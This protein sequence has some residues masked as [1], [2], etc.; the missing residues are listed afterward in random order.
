MPPS[1]HAAPLEEGT[2]AG[3]VMTE[4][5]PDGAVPSAFKETVRSTPHHGGLRTVLLMQKVGDE[6]YFD[7]AGF[8]GRTMGLDAE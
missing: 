5:L 7:A 8:A 4:A 3:R 2:L 1:P 6:R